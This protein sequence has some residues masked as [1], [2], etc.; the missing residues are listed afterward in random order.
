MAR[1]STTAASTALSIPT[2]VPTP[3][4]KRAAWEVRCPLLRCRPRTPANHRRHRQPPYPLRH[5]QIRNRAD[6]IQPRPQIQH[7]HGQYALLHRPGPRNSFFNAYSG[8]GRIFALRVLHGR[9]PVCYE[10]GQSLRDYIYVG[11]VARANV[12]CLEDERADFR[13][14]NVAG[15]RGTTVLEYARLITRIAGQAIEPLISGEYRF[16]DTRH[17]VSSGE[18]LQALGWQPKVPLE[19]TIGEYIEWIKRQPNLADFYATAQA[20]MRAANVLRKASA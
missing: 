17:T 4:L 9:P 1:A 5:L 7:S 11:D 13:S 19:Q 10:D 8:I 12:L 2:L 18:A 15:Q 16:G 14:F 20:N 3:Q 6:L